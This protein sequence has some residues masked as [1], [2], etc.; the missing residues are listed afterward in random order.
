M[1]E[2]VAVAIDG[3]SPA[4]RALDTGIEIARRFGSTLTVLTVQALRTDHES[5]IPWKAEEDALRIMLEEGRERARARGVERVEVAYLTGH[6]LE[7][8]LEFAHRSGV[9][10]LVVGSRG[11]SRGSRL[12]LGSVSSGLVQSAHCPVLVVRPPRA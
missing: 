5:S 7:T 10:L 6:A 4:A 11:L 12:L 8:I 9:D 1:F 3:S 2:K